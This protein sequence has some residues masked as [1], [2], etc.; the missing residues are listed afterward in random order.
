MRFLQ[1]LESSL[2]VRYML[3]AIIMLSYAIHI[4]ML[5][6]LVKG[7]FGPIWFVFVFS[8][9]DPR[10]ENAEMGCTSQNVELPPP[11][12][13]PTG[14]PELQPSHDWPGVHREE[15]DYMHPEQP[16]VQET[17]CPCLKASSF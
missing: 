4:H 7:T 2:D 16:Y 14:L 17:Y 15:G 10:P 3:Y 11:P 8:S 13:R 6:N 5:S 9:P 12:A 1:H